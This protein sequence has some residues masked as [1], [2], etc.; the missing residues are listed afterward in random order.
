MDFFYNAVLYIA[1]SLAIFVLSI[2]VSLGW[3]TGEFLFKNADLRKHK[4]AKRTGGSFVESYEDNKP[5]SE[6]GED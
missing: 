4:K 1:Y 6:G 2:I 5:D 3:F